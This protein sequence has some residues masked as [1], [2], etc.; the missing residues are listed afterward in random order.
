MSRN[1]SQTLHLLTS[2][3]PGLPDII[4]VMVFILALAYGAQMLSIDSDLGRHLTIGN[5]ILDNH[6]V[7]TR[8]LFSHTLSDHPRP[9]YEWLSQILFALANRLLGLDGAIIFT[10]V[11][12][13]TTFSLVF[14]FANRRCGSPIIA[15]LITLLAAGASSIHWLPRPHIITF[16]LF[17]IWV[18]NLE[19]LSKGKTVNLF[20]FPLMMLCWAN[21]HGG[22]VFGILAWFAY[23]A[24]WIWTTRQREPGNQTGRKLLLVG[25]TSL[26]ASVITPDFW[27]NWEAVLNN[28]SSFILSRTV[29]TMPPNLTAPSVIPFTILLG[30]TIILFFVNHKTVSARHLFLLTGLGMVSLFMARNI[31][32]F[33]IACTPIISEL[34]EASLNRLKAWKQIEKRFS[35]FAGQFRWTIIPL[36]ATSL[37]VLFFANR[38]FNKGQSIFQF[39]SQVFPVQALNWLEENPQKGRMF[40]EF[41]WGGYILYREWPKQRVFLDSQSDFYG[42]T[43]MRDYD[44]IISMQ[45]NWE[46]LLKKYQVDWALLPAEWKLAKELIKQG[47]EPVYQ[48]QTA[49]V[50]IK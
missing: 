31:P 18:E 30:V 14:Q 4:F 39:N 7:P 11:I 48:D 3:A 32:L 41:N 19:Q 24:G 45:A 16:L 17:A 25:L 28:R 21:L 5:Y 13:A 43:L 10:A 42:E 12:I 6:T 38:Y 8:D 40:N 9:P 2:L 34:T 35:G 33:V 37:A 50:L 44:Q 26:A 47:W 49:I 23:M 15:F 1:K 20:V 46:N 22:F 29:E 27:H 36:V